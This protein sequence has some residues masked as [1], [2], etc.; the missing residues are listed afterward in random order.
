[1]ARPVDSI[2]AGQMGDALLDSDNEENPSGKTTGKHPADKKASE[3]KGAKQS[4]AKVRSRGF[5][6][7]QELKSGK[8]KK[9]EMQ[10]GSPSSASIEASNASHS[11]VS[12]QSQVSMHPTQLYGPK[13]LEFPENADRVDS[14][15]GGD[16]NEKEAPDDKTVEEKQN[17]PATVAEEPQVKEA[18]TLPIEKPSED[19]TGAEHKEQKDEKTSVNQEMAMQG[20]PPSEDRQQDEVPDAQIHGEHEQKDQPTKPESIEAPESEINTAELMEIVEAEKHA[21]EKTAAEKNC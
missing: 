5:A 4:E 13:T 7:P 11:M 19:P 9:E 20:P 1:M 21:A 8:K 17:I 18:T 3:K 15:D 16:K 10:S 14:S 12:P 2:T 6:K